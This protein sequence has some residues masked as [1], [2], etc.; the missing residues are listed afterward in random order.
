[1][2]TGQLSKGDIVLCRF[3]LTTGGK[4]KKRPALVWTAP[5]CAD[6]LELYIVVMITGTSERWQDDIDL[7]CDDQTNLPISCAIRPARMATIERD[8]IDKQIGRISTQA[9]KALQKVIKQ[10]NS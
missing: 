5:R 10:Y 9:E 3:P 7:P 2:S 8:I 6:N 4:G 1:M